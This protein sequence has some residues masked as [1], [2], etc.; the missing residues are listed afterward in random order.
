MKS[1]VLVKYVPDSNSVF[2]INSDN[3]WIDT[4]NLSFVLNDYDRY[5][6]ESL[7]TLKD[8]GTV[9]EVVALTVGPPEV[10]SVLRT[11]LAMGADRAIHVND[12]SLYG[13]DPLTV[14]HLI[15]SAIKQEHFSL[16]LAGLQADDDNHTQV[17]GLVAGL[18]D[19]SF[20]SA[21]M[22][23][24]LLN[25]KTLRVNRELVNNELEVVDLILPSVVTVQTGINTPRYASL[26]GIMAA[27]R[28][29]FVTLSS[30]DLDNAPKDEENSTTLQTVSFESPPVGKGADI[31]S[32]TPEEIARQLLT[33][34]REKT[35][36]L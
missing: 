24:E 32:G 18:L 20:A 1:I 33:H 13:I 10:G 16:V 27:K 29:P 30:T 6:L 36:V 8:N 17:G 22:E 23:L 26:K 15:V 19:Y 25:E 4:S 14:A 9:T 11:C 35:G 12:D 7:L 21:A 2:R 28:K 34:I 3:T 31:L 5:A